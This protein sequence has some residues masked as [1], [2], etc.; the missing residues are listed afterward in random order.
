MSMHHPQ[1]IKITPKVKIGIETYR[2]I[3]EQVLLIQDI[4]PDKD[5]VSFA[6]YAKYILK[7][8]SDEEKREII[9][10]FGKPLFI[11]DKEVCSSPINSR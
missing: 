4:N 9:K 1:T 7:E 11:H 5:Q 8:G 3:R 10:V 2:K 6:E